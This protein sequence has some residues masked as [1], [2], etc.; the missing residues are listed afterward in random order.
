VG[1]WAD[2]DKVSVAK[3]RPDGSALLVLRDDR[4]PERVRETRHL[5]VEVGMR[6]VARERAREGGRVSG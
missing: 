4:S 1:T 2:L 6:R 3:P 5:S